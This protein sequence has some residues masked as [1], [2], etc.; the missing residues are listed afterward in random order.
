MPRLE[1]FQSAALNLGPGQLFNVEIVPD[2]SRT[3]TVGTSG[4]TDVVLVLFEDVG[5]ELQY[6]AG[7]DDSGEDHMPTAVRPPAEPG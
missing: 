3:Y 4:A 5:G 2:A 6:L 7:D 1:P